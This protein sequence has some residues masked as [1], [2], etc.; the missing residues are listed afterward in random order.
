MAMLNNQRV[1]E[2]VY[3]YIY[4]GVLKRVYSKSW[5]FIMEQYGTSNINTHSVPPF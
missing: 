5:S 2:G 3:I 4:G 1:S